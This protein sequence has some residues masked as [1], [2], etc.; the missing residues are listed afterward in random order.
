MRKINLFGSLRKLGIIAIVSAIGISI[1]FVSCI[2]NG[3]MVSSEINVSSFNKIESAGIAEIRY[4][5]SEEYKVIITTDSNLI[6]LIKAETKNNTLELGVKPGNYTF[7]KIEIDVYCPTLTSVTISGS[8]KFYS[9]GKIMEPKF[10]IT[11]SGSGNIDVN[12]ECDTFSSKISGSGKT[13]VI[14]KS[15]ETSIDI[16]G[17]GEFNGADFISNNVEIDLSGSGEADVFVISR[18]KAKISGS[19]RLNYYGDP[20]D[21]ASDISGSGQINK[22]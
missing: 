6:N 8:G 18:L 1:A 12:I 15:N 22:K 3:E 16:S 14:G 5:K 10:N 20:A 17:S 19:G 13:T 11:V 9:D 7:T 4:Y 21:V 2:G